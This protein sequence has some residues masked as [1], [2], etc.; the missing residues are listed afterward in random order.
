MLLTSAVNASLVIN[1]L[2]GGAGLT[3]LAGAVVALYKLRPDVNSAAVIQAQ[4]TMEMME[5]LNSNLA[6]E[7]DRLEVDRQRLKAVCT[8]QEQLIQSMREII[9]GVA[10]MD[11]SAEIPR[12]LRAG[13]DEAD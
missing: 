6:E 13:D 4:G 10:L 7:L 3:G 5:K 9:R 12:R 8:E 2:L 11:E 1:L